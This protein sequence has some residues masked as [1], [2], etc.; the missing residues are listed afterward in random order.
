MTVRVIRLGLGWGVFQN[1]DL[2]KDERCSSGVHK[3]EKSAISHAKRVA[4]GDAEI[5]IERSDGSLTRMRAEDEP[6][7]ST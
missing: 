6:S 4:T 1:D 2:V 5:L 7:D 3:T